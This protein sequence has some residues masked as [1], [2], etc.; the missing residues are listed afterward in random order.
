MELQVGD[1]VIYYPRNSD[2][3]AGGIVAERA[4]S[5]LTGNP[6]F[7]IVDFARE[8][9]DPDAGQWRGIGDIVGAWEGKHTD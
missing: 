3:M 8:I 4:V 7:R 9:A 5:P 1:R 2:I 6:R